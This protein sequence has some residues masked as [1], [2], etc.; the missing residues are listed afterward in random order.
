VMGPP[1]RRSLGGRWLGAVCGVCSRWHRGSPPL[2]RLD[3]AVG[4]TGQRGRGTYTDDT[5][6]MIALVESLIERG[7]V[8]DQH[9]ACAFTDW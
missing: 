2:L 6:T 7:R 1:P 8:D 4:Q 9:L 3:V 5:Q